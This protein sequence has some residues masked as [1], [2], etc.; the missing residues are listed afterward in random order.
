MSRGEEIAAPTPAE[1]SAR[2]DEEAAREAASRHGRF[3]DW[4]YADVEHLI[5]E[6]EIGMERDDA[7]HGRPQSF[8]G[9]GG[10][11]V[12]FRTARVFVEQGDYPWAVPDVLAQIAAL[13]RYA[14]DQMLWRSADWPDGIDEL[15]DL[16]HRPAAL[17]LLAIEE[18]AKPFTLSLIHI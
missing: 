3:D 4:G 11:A 10:A 16:E 18:A 7:T 1:W 17:A 2:M 15:Y 6:L 9:S 12:A 5:E 8:E 14:L 13:T